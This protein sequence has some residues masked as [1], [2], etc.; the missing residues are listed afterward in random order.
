MTAERSQSIYE[1]DWL[2]V[3][4]SS[5]GHPQTEN[6]QKEYGRKNIDQVRCCS[7]NRTQNQVRKLIAEPLMGIY[8]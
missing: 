7:A 3:I 6:C 8:L 5:L 2:E 4:K 1:S